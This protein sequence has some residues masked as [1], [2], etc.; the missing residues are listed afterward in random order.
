MTAFPDEAQIGRLIE[1]YRAIEQAS[2]DMLAAALD[3]DWDRVAEVQARCEA[4]IDEVR[5]AAPRVALSREAQ[6]AKLRIMTEIVR[7]EARIRRLAYPWTARYEHLVFSR[8]T[9][10]PMGERTR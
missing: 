10:G 9:R 2:R 5:G 6:R 1:R 7:N 3:G 4:L 8:R